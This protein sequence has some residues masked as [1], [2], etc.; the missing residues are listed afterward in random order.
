MLECDYGMIDGILNK[1]HQGRKGIC[2]D[3]LQ[4]KKEFLL[5]FNPKSP[6]DQMCM[7]RE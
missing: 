1:R 5:T 7:E 4:E 3:K 2:S 6:P